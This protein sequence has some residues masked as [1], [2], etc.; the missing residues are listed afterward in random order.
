MAR[1]DFEQRFVNARE[2]FEHA[3][4]EIYSALHDALEQEALDNAEEGDEIDVE[5]EF[6]SLN[7]YEGDLG[8]ILDKMQD[9]VS[10][11]S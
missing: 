8:L 4:G 3:Y 2:T 6:E 1:K 10:R 5:E 9:E 7:E 11:L